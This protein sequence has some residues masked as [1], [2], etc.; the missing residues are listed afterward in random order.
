MNYT[1]LRRYL[2]LISADAR[3]NK[4]TAPARTPARV[5]RRSVLAR[6][7]DY[8]IGKVQ[9]DFIQRKISVLDLL[10]EHDVAV[11]IIARERSGSV[12]KHGEFPDLKFLGGNSFVVGLND[13]DFIQKPIRSTVLG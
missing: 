4:K 8:V 3:S 13:R 9:R 11:A 7:E 12:G 1:R 6:Q 5:S 10:G 2:L